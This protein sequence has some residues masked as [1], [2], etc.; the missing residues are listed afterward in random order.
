MDQ[1]CWP[2]VSDDHGFVVTAPYEL[3]WSWGNCW[4]L[5]FSSAFLSCKAALRFL[6]DESGWHTPNT[7]AFQC[8]TAQS[9]LVFVICMHFPF[10]SQ[11]LVKGKF[12]HPIKE[13]KP[14]SNTVGYQGSPFV[15]ALELN[16]TNKMTI[17][18][19]VYKYTCSVM[20]LTHAESTQS[21]VGNEGRGGGLPVGPQCTVRRWELRKQPSQEELWA[22][23]RSHY[24]N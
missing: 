10:L 12:C 1:E 22:S 19:C 16:I 21:C 9:F 20:F 8:F 14:Y 13:V 11:L 18:V 15:T 6:V 7:G 17:L 2:H 3:T 5:S 4:W 23:P 24:F